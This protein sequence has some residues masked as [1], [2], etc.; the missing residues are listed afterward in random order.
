MHQNGGKWNGYESGSVYLMGHAHMDVTMD[1]YNHIT[2]Q[3]R[4]KME[5]AKLNSTVV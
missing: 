5:L 3:S 1:V 2:E 4:I